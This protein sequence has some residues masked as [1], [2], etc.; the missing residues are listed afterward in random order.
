MNLADWVRDARERTIGLVDDLDDSQLVVPYLPTIQPPLWELAHAVYFQE[1]WVL[2]KGAGQKPSRPDIDK[3]FDSISIDHEARWRL[4]PERSEAL[5]YA[6]EVRDRVL[7]L[8]NPS[9][10][11][12]YY[13]TYSVFHED[14]H[15]EALAYSRQALGYS[16]PKIAGAHSNGT[17]GGDAEFSGG[18]FQLGA[19]KDA[20]FAFDNEKWAHEVEVKPFRISRAPVSQT[21]FAR[22][23]DDN[24]YRRDELWSDEGRKWRDAAQAEHPL[25]WRRGWEHRK[26]DQWLPIDAKHP[27]MHLSWFEADA[28]CRWAKRRLPTEAEWEHAAPASNGVWEWTATTFAPYPGFTPD[29]YQDYSR[30]SFHTRKVLRGGSWATT[31]R[32]MRPTLRN[33]YQPYRR[34][35]FAGFRTCAL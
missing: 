30:T 25:Y 8:G 12:R 21:E 24:G 20:S 19:P 9:E 11:L 35:V 10:E 2:R 5:A 27:V 33:F 29:M 6:R 15:V 32:M 26:F 31:A 22:F 28:Y 34:D 16:A 23:V 13:I 17:A 18:T 3:L 1:F 7:D 14:M 4:V